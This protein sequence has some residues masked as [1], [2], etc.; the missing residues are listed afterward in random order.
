[1]CRFYGH[2]T[3]GPNSH[4]YTAAPEE[5]DFLKQLALTTPFGVPRW[6]FEEYSFAID[7]PVNRQCPA[8]A[9]ISVYRAY[10]NRAAQNDSNHRYTTD[11]GVYQQMLARGWSGEG[12]VM[13][14][15]A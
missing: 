8:S 10:N 5:C 15:P 3:I 14:A 12:V 13:C 9:P 6:N 7:V 4:F 1:M 11:I 2:F